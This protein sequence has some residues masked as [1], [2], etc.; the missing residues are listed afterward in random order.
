MNFVHNLKKGTRGK[1]RE[2]LPFKCFNYGAVG[3]CAMKYPYNEKNKE[4]ESSYRERS[5][6]KTKSNFRKNNFKKKSLI[7]KNSSSSE[8]SSNEDSEEEVGK[9][10]F[11]A[12]EEEIDEEEVE[13]EVDIEGDLIAALE[14]LSIKRKKNKKL[15]KKLNE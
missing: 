13:A 10:L 2:K 1:Y 8:A 14:E 7:S 3:H 4:G 11:M 6:W 5:G 15:S 12:F 9:A